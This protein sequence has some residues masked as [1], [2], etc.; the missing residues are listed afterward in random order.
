M[1]LQIDK[2]TDTFITI[3]C[4]PI[5]GT[6]VTSYGALGHSA[7]VYFTLK[8]YKVWWQSLISNIFKILHSTVIKL[9][10]SFFSEHTKIAS[11]FCNMMCMYFVSFNVCDWKWHEIHIRT[12]VTFCLQCFDTV[13]WA[14]GRASNLQ[15][16]SDDVYSYMS[17][18]QCRL[19]AYG[20][21]DAT[22]SQNPN[23][24]WLI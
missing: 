21:A 17:G 9:S 22:A 11:F 10:F 4:S 20:P 5:W 23:I 13:G 14:P 6:G 12:C 7:I 2:Q 15:K 1:C 19:F 3:L 18:A 24:S 16:L 8:L